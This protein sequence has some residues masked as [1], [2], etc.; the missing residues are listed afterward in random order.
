MELKVSKREVGKKGETNQ[1]RREGK[2]PAV[3]YGPKRQP[4]G[5]ALSRIEWEVA[6]R[7]IPKGSLSTVI[8]TL[9]GEKGSQQALVKEVQYHPTTYAV[10]HLDFIEVRKDVT[11]NVKV[12]LRFTGVEECE[13]IKQGGALRPII[14]A[15]RVNCLPD[16]IPKELLL[17]VTDLGIKQSRRLK[18]IQMPEGVR[19]L[20]KLHE[21]AVVV[22]KR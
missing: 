15:L 7:Q 20:A 4:E 17:D 19:P 14:R 21:V 12:P 16:R 22:A 5:L 1:L 18:A 9:Q 8:F 2:I 10:L 3:V 13:G 6:L 11:V